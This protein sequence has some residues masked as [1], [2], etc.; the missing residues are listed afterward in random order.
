VE[1]AKGVWGE[2]D[3]TRPRRDRVGSGFVVRCFK[4]C[5]FRDLRSASHGHPPSIFPTGMAHPFSSFAIEAV[6]VPCQ[7]EA[8]AHR[9]S[10][11]IGLANPQAHSYTAKSLAL[12]HTQI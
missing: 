5:S 4:G 2:G 3:V 10:H 12:C 8:S 9:F 7:P 6:V 11:R 1:F